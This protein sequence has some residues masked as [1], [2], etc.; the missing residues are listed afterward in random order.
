MQPADFNRTVPINGTT[1]ISFHDIDESAL[2]Q[3]NLNYVNPVGGRQKIV[4]KLFDIDTDPTQ[5]KSITWNQN[6]LAT[7][8]N[9]SFTSLSPSTDSSHFSSATSTIARP[10]TSIT[11]KPST[12]LQGGSIAAIVLGIFLSITVAAASGTVWHLYRHNKKRDVTRG[13]PTASSLYFLPSQ[14]T[15]HPTPQEMDAV[16]VRNELYPDNGRTELPGE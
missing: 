16:T 8:T 2:S 4:G 12:G 1:I 7:S 6:A 9:S 13:P 15:Y 11:T 14:T 10:T 5:P 3:L